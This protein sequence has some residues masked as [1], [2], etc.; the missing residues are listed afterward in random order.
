MHKGQGVYAHNNVPDVTQTFQNTV[1]VKNWYE[2]RFQAAVASAS[3]RE[4]P[5]KERVI[6]QALPDGHPGL[7]ET[8]KK[9]FDKAMLTSPPPA[10]IKKPS[11]Y[12]DGNLPDRLNTYGLADS[13]H[14][15][16]GPNPAAE[17][18]KPAPRYMTTTNKELYEVKPQQDLT[19]HPE[20]FQ[21][22]KSPYGLTDAL[23]KSV[24]GEATDQSN[25]VGGK[26]ARGE[27]T[28]RP[29]ESGNVYGVSVFVDEY[30]KW[31]SALKGMPLEE[32]ASK[33]QTK[34]F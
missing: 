22:T 29:G 10:N 1:L 4:Q 17:A 15:T 14:Y 5:T 28:R 21:S 31:G 26:G 2:D 8:T 34:Y 11:M 18:A 12:T 24:R 30:A 16:T 27:I 23:T 20:A 9:E 25:V 7:W 32:T 33:K 6:H 19:A 3:G 13:I